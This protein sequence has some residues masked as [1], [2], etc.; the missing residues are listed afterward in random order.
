[1]FTTEDLRALVTE[2]ASPAVSIF[3]P[4]HVKG[5]EI[6]QD[7]VRLRKLLDGA[8][9]ALAAR[10]MRSE[11]ARDMLMPGRALEQDALFWRFQE[12]GLALFFAPGISRHYK[13]GIELEEKFVVGPAFNV[14]PLL[15]LLAA[16]GRFLLLTITNEGTRLFEAT[17]FTLSERTGLSV[18]EGVAA[19]MRE[20]EYDE[21]FDVTP[22]GRPRTGAAGL[23]AGVGQRLITGESPEDL[24]KA[25]RIEYLHRVVAGVQDAVGSDP[26]PVVLAADSQ[27]RGHIRELLKLRNLLPEDLQ[28]NPSAF[29]IEDLHRRAWQHV[30]PYFLAAR[31]EAMSRFNT[32]LGNGDPRASLSLDEIVKA[33]RFSRVEMLFLAQGEAVWGRYDEDAD[34]VSLHEQQDQDDIELLDY[35]AVQTLLHGGHVDILPRAEMPRQVLSAAIFRY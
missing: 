11:D 30:R 16:D 13:V 4:T 1:M 22:A 14:R 27:I 35:A 21:I 34:T 24:R 12:E 29:G 33:A 8:E 28:L 9:R 26:A 31:E 20:T 18:P 3:L 17:R 5:R 7:P 23:G 6:R 32:L 25:E 2:T 15:P 10:G 19:V